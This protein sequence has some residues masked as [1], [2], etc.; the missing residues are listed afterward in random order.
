[1]V[2]LVG[3]A[4]AQ[5]LLRAELPT[6]PGEN[7]GAAIAELK[8]GALLACWY[9]GKHEEDASV[10]ILCARSQTDGATWSPAWTAVAPRDRA[11]GAAAPDKSLG[12][13][14]LTVT[15][16]GRVWMIHGVI[17][18]RVLPVIGETCRNWACGRIDARVSDDERPHLVARPRGSSTSTARCPARS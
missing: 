5:D 18:S 7:H 15:P 9:S 8:S 1:M 6:P 14:T 10:R 17:Q 2:T 12:N 16:D 13:V 11:V 4:P 3:A